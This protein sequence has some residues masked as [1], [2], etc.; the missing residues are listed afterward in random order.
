M[1]IITIITLMDY[2]TTLFLAILTFDL[3]LVA[4][5]AI[6]EKAETKKCLD[7]STL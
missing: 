2:F 3:F 4:I 5:I 1:E 6:M 7:F